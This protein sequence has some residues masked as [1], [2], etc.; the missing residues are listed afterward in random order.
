M[1]WV[2]VV[3]VAGLGER[4]SLGEDLIWVLADA[5]YNHYKRISIDSL[6]NNFPVTPFGW[7]GRRSF[8]ITSITAF[9]FG[10]QT[11]DRLSIQKKGL[12]VQN[13]LPIRFLC[14]VTTPKA[15]MERVPSQ[16]EAVVESTK[17]YQDDLQN[18]GLRIKQHKDQ[19]K[20]LKTQKNIVEA[21]I[22]D[23]QVTIGKYHTST[24]SVSEIEEGTSKYLNQG[25]SA[26]G[27]I[28]QLNAHPEIEVSDSPLVKDVL[29]IV[30]TLG[31]VDD[32]NL[33]RLLAEY[34]G[35]ETMMAIV[36]KTF[37]GVKALESYDKEGIIDR[38]S[39]LHGIGSSFGRTL[40][41]RFRVICLNGLIPYVGEFVA[42]DPQRR[43][44]LL[45]P[46]LPGGETPCG[47]VGY[48]VNLVHIDNQNLFCVTSSSHGLRETLFYHLFSHLQV[49]RT[50]KDMQQALPCIK[51]GAVSL[52]GGM[53]RSPGVF[54]LGPREEAQVKFPR[55]SGKSSLPENNEI[56]NILK[57]K[58]WNQERL[59]EDIRREQ[60]L[61]D[62]AKFNLEIKKKE[63]VRFLAQSSQYAPSQYAPDQPPQAPLQQTPAGQERFTPR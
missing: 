21:S 9:G 47:F 36:C 38:N 22:R 32:E 51:N 41:G 49:Y 43:L 1:V 25:K 7:K 46:K 26:A 35:K 19:I 61:L 29:G 42:D 4:M 56:E 10:E 27:L 40:E 33:G 55:I 17:N 34:L 11:G 12:L 57:S 30:A 8:V 3:R 14:T 15:E 52:D 45:K 39:G 24:G 50:E 60:S 18:L 63:F 37:D 13:S 44:D 5:V 23:M 58:K 20:F 59:L 31:K 53:I 54:N 16:A 48:A 6:D 28:C 62:Q 2:P